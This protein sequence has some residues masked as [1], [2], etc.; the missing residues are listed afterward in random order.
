[1]PPTLSKQVAPNKAAGKS[2]SIVL[3]TKGA[4]LKKQVVLGEL[5]IIGKNSRRIKV[6]HSSQQ[7]T[8][9]RPKQ[10]VVFQY[11]VSF[12]VPNRP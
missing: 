2:T 9:S 7:K 6:V 12:W 11:L 5:N 8:A 3:K 4:P 1:M 10:A